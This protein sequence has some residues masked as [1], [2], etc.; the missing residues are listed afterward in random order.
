VEPSELGPDNIPIDVLKHLAWICVIYE[1]VVTL[2]HH[3]ERHGYPDTKIDGHA[4]SNRDALL[5]RI[6]AH[7][8]GG[9]RQFSAEKFF[10]YLFGSV[11]THEGL[12]QAI[13]LKSTT[14][15]ALRNTFVNFCNIADRFLE[16]TRT[17]EFRQHHGTLDK[18]DINEWIFFVTSLVRAAERKARQQRTPLT[19]PDFRWLSEKLAGKDYVDSTIGEMIKYT[20]VFTKKE[21]TMRELFDLMELPIDRRRYWW[22]RAKKFRG[23]HYSEYFQHGTCHVKNCSGMISRDCKGWEEGEVIEEPWDVHIENGL[24]TRAS[25]VI[26]TNCSWE[27]DVEMI[28]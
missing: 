22:A 15:I 10:L 27:T 16:P 3:P 23:E 21:R 26:G 11:S 28:V 8:C 4:I 14:G 20:N 12:K 2:L 13:S 17:V 25:D 24:C 7:T 6:G 9:A 18:E 19:P 5:S 1:D